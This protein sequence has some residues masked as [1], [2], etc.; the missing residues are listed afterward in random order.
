MF[1]IYCGEKTENVDG[2]CESCREKQ[3]TTQESKV[4]NDVV[5]EASDVSTNNMF[6]EAMTSASGNAMS[7]TE[8]SVINDVASV[9]ANE[10]EKEKASIFSKVNLIIAGLIAGS[11]GII[12]F[13]ISTM[14]ALA[15]N[16]AGK[17]AINQLMSGISD[18]IE[19]GEDITFLSPY[20]V[21]RMSFL[22]SMIFKV[23]TDTE[24]ATGKVH[25][26]LFY[27]FLVLIPLISVLVS[28]ILFRQ[29]GIRAK[30]NKV[31]KL[32]G[33]N[34]ESRQVFYINTMVAGMFSVLFALT[35]V[36]PITM[37]EASFFGF[38]I[39]V[40]RYFDFL[41][42][43]V[44]TFLVVFFCNIIITRNNA[45]IELLD[46]QRQ[47][48][49][50]Y[51]SILWR[52]TLNATIITIAFALVV[53][54]KSHLWKQILLLITFL[55]NLILIIMNTLLGG[56]LKLISEEAKLSLFK[57]MGGV[58]KSGFII[59][60]IVFVLLLLYLFMNEFKKLDRSDSRKYWFSVT[61]ITGLVAVTQIFF[62]S[63]S[64]IDLKISMAG[65]A[66]RF[67]IT[68]SVIMLT[69]FILLIGAA[70]G[71]AVF[72]LN[73]TVTTVYKQIDDL[74][75][76]ILMNVKLKGKFLLAQASA[77]FIVAV[78]L[79]ML[80]TKDDVSVASVG[81]IGAYD[82]KSSFTDETSVRL[83]EPK[84][85]RLFDKGYV[86]RSD[87]VYYSY[88]NS[89][90]K[91]LELDYVSEY[92]FSQNTDRIMKIDGNKISIIN[93]AGKAIGKQEIT[94]DRICAVTDDFN[95]IAFVLE[96]ELNIYDNDKD[97]FISVDTGEFCLDPEAGRYTF[98]NTG[99][100][101]YIVEQGVAKYNLADKATTILQEDGNYL[102]AYDTVYVS[103]ELQPLSIEDNS[104]LEYDYSNVEYGEITDLVK[105]TDGNKETVISNINDIY[106]VNGEP[107][108]FLISFKNSRDQYLFKA[109]DNK[110]TNISA[111]IRYVSMN[112]TAE[113]KE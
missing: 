111:E 107:D 60:A 37:Y 95:K 50:S 13:I 44:L 51:Q 59:L 48:I 82:G 72:F 91:M 18:Y 81:L 3:Q 108:T 79:S 67:G 66:T 101:L 32:D 40:V 21:W 84:D 94:Y 19:L 85:I 62:N 46:K 16:A 30:L 103:G 28:W 25:I 93:R 77:I 102:V 83:M 54:V 6:K 39:K 88:K 52:H 97:E 99:K 55:P 112:S 29:Q 96:Q 20:T 12:S 57:Q 68:S 15:V 24:V 73:Q 110:L 70:G 35:S 76:K 56:D 53:L 45:I 92:H 89:K 71:L 61:A 1:C 113:G 109:K 41:S 5:N 8:N 14:V 10:A 7:E 80:I 86:F 31:F 100:N 34:G 33:F 78:L 65:D 74:M 104:P 90:I 22:N 26:N 87:D 63:I 64:L 9:G 17:D 43:L 2:V 69:A 42:A 75:I 11:T 36:L 106:E 4:A 47:I 58:N 23:V 27:I 49:V 98:D 105:W 38:T